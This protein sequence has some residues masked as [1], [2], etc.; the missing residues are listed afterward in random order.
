MSRGQV[1]VVAGAAVAL[2]LALAW[3][4]EQSHVRAL[5]AELEAHGHLGPFRELAQD[6]ALGPTQHKR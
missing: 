4:M 6:L 2:T 1:I 3:L 5:R